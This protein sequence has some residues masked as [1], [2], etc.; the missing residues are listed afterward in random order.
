MLAGNDDTRQFGTF[1]TTDVRNGFIR[2]VYSLVGIQ[3]LVTTAIAVGIM[4][5]GESKLRANS[6][7]TLGLLIVSSILTIAT[8]CTLC[9]CPHLMR[10]YPWN[11]VILGLFTIGESIVV[12]L[13]SVQ[14]TTQSVIMAFG[15]TCFIV[16][17]LTIF[18]CQTK[19]DFTGC[20]PYLFVG[21]LC[22]MGFGFFM[23]LGSFFLTGEAFHQLNLI[24]AFG[25]AL[26]M[27][28]Y[29]VYDTQLIVGGKH[30]R[31]A[32]FGVDDYAFAALSLYIDIVQLFLYLL[33]LF[34]N[35]R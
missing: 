5:I 18:A 30:Q 16:I 32:E 34:G 26:L 2:K 17:A 31:Q 24:Y 20:G 33:Q 8:M 3:L 14:F 15:I 22:L 21:C 29:I 28:C 19:Y 10:K 7:A 4:K 12:G 23:W 27:S 6:E 1:T 25:G 35:R 9:C 11:Y 13:I